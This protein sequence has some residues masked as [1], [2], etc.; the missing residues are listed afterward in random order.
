MYCWGA[1]AAASTS[2]KPRGLSVAI[3]PCWCHLKAWRGG[4]LTGSTGS[5][6][7]GLAFAA[8]SR[9]GFS[10]LAFC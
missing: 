6:V 4:M 2:P 10:S 7:G 5:L 1:H 9:D 8:P 3:L